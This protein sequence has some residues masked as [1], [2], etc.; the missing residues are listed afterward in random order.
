[1]IWDDPWVRIALQKGGTRIPPPLTALAAGQRF[2]CMT[3]ATLLLGC[4]QWIELVGTRWSVAEV[5]QRLEGA[6]IP[7]LFEDGVLVA[8]CVLR[9]KE[10]FWILETLRARRGR[11]TPLLR[12]TIPWL[13]ARGVVSLGYTWELSA[14]ALLSAWWRGWLNSACELQYGWAWSSSGTCGFCPTVS[15]SSRLTLPTLFQ[16]SGGAAIV[17]DSGLDDGWGYVSVVRGEPDWSAIAKQGGWRAL[18]RRAVTGPKGWSWTGE[19][20]VVGFLNHPGTH[21]TTEWVTSEI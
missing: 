21:V 19:F 13:W 14:P 20:V 15:S 2:E 3:A 18:W 12:A 8:T 9:P 1:M 10:G 7:C 16:D 11:G 4:A 17:S 5:A 6:W